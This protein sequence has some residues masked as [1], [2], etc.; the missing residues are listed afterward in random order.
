MERSE[1]RADIDAARLFPDFA[2]FH[3]GYLLMPTDNPAKG[4]GEASSPE[5]VKAVTGV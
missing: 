2:A 4:I 5:R 1:I 3:P